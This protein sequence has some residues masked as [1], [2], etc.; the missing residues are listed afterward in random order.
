MGSGVMIYLPN[1]IKIG[2]G[3]KKIIGEGIYRHRQHGDL[4]SLLVL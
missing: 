3:V 2:S 4:K 1:F